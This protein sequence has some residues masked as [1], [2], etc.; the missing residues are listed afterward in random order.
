LA[1][2]ILTGDLNLVCEHDPTWNTDVFSNP[3]APL[4][5]IAGRI[6]ALGVTNVSGNVQCYGCCFYDLSST[7]ASNHDAANQLTYNTSA[8]AAFLTALQAQAIAV[9]GSALGQTGFSAPG[10]LFYT[11]YS[12]N[13][14]H[15][16][17]PLR[18]EIACI[19]MLKVSHNVM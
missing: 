1:G 10:T 4:D 7:D 8:S 13:L 15:G 14:T 12:T 3:R 16:G 6:K 17:K 9:S 19:P 5:Y 2:G 18:L 11:Y